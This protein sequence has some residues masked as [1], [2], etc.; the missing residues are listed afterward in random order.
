MSFFP[1]FAWLYEK[2]TNEMDEGSACPSGL[3]P[4]AFSNCPLP[5]EV[6]S[7]QQPISAS[8]NWAFAWLSAALRGV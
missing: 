8:S 2:G 7:I 6:R 3:D 1:E 5:T 4:T